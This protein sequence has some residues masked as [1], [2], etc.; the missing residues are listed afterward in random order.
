VGV[1]ALLRSVLTTS[2]EG[3]GMPEERVLRR[4]GG[5]SLSLRN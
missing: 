2:P 4:Q 3:E 1:T 5:R